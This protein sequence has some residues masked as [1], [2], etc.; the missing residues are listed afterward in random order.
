MQGWVRKGKPVGF[1]VV[2]DAL[3]RGDRLR[4]FAGRREIASFTRPIAEGGT[5]R[6]PANIATPAF[7]AARFYKVHNFIE[8]PGARFRIMAGKLSV[9]LFNRFI[10]NTGYKIA[11]HNAGFLQDVLARGN[12]HEIATYLSWNDGLAYAEWL[13]A[14]TAKSIMLP[15]ENQWLTAVGS[16]GD[17]LYGVNWEWTVTP[18]CCGTRV[19]RLLNSRGRGVYIPEGRYGNSSIR[20]VEDLK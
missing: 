4:I 11:G 15:T 17:R 3:S 8:V 18:D 1:K 13:S 2:S 19:L 14:I 6:I 20:L 5:V 9:G 12:Q 10:I 16:V 7:D